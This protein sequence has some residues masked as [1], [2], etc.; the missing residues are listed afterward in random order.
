MEGLRGDLATYGVVVPQCS[1]LRLLAS[2][3]E[4]FPGGATRHV[5]LSELETRCRRA[6]NRGD[7]AGELRHALATRSLKSHTTL[8]GSLT[9]IDDGS[10]R[11]LLEQDGARVEMIMHHQVKD[12]L[13]F[14]AYKGLDLFS[15]P[16]TRRCRLTRCRLLDG[17]GGGGG[18]GG[19]GGGYS[20]RT[21]MLIP[22]DMTGAYIHTQTQTQTHTHIHTY[23]HPHPTHMR[24]TC[25]QPW[26]CRWT[27][28]RMRAF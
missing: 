26:N 1:L 12:W 20:T 17:G 24:H 22:T 27:V 19:S 16:G 4:R 25:V 2:V 14:M 8:C 13:A 15:S 9:R 6:H 10:L 5:L 23:T 7:G 11:F 21:K 3:L 28:Q 18:G